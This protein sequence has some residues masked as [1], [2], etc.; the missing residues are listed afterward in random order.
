MDNVYY[1]W[2]S[3]VIVMQNQPAGRSTKR[4][5]YVA[6]AA[7]ILVVAIVVGV[8]FSTAG[9][10]GKAGS[11]DS[12]SKITIVAAENFWGSLVSQLGGTHVNVT[13]IVS[14]PNTDPHEYESNPAD[15]IAITNARLVIVNG[16]GYDTWALNIIS[17]ENNPN[18]V[19]LNVQKL[20]NQSVDANPHFWYSPYYV[21]YTVKAM[22]KDLISI[23]PGDSAYYKQQYATLNASLW[24]SYMSREVEIKQKFAGTPVA[25]TE[26]IFVYMANAT[27]LEVVSP[28]GFMKAVAEGTD[29]SA[30]DVAT[31]EQLLATGNSTVRVLVYNEQTVTPLTQSIKSLAAQHEVPTIGVTETIQPPDATFQAWMGG[32]LFDLQNALN[33]Q[34]L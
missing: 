15:A 7:T 11:S 2:P 28:P 34:V 25:S 9:G 17:A 5:L 23:D 10:S 31:F 26:S 27:G 29:P 8:Y 32:E 6:V 21:N 13:S 12:T 20:I 16:A 24:S 30:Q 14:D 22:Y 4:I 1:T 3:T 19:V 18:Q 33:A